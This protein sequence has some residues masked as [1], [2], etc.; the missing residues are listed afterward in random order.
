MEGIEDAGQVESTDVGQVESSR[1]VLP[2]AEGSSRVIGGFSRGRALGNVLNFPDAPDLLVDGPF[3]AQGI[4]RVYS[5]RSSM[6]SVHKPSMTMK[7]ETK[8]T[9]GPILQKLGRKYSPVRKCRIFAH[10]DGNWNVKGLFQDALEE[11]EEI[12]W[13]ADNGQLCLS[14]CAE[15][16]DASAVPTASQSSHAPG[17]GARVASDAPVSQVAVKS[18]D[19]SSSELIALLN[20]PEHLAQSIKNA[21]LR[22]NYAKYKAC[23]QAQET[24]SQKIK[25]GTWP[26]G[27]KK[28]TATNIIE[29]FV[30]RT[31]WHHYVKPA[32]HDISHFEPLKQWL[33]ST[34][35]GPADAAVWGSEQ[36]S[37]S[38]ADLQ[39]EKD[40]RQ[41]LKT[42]KKKEGD[43]KGQTGKGKKNQV[44]KE[45]EEKKKGKKVLFRLFMAW[46]W[47]MVLT[48]LPLVAAASRE[49][50]PFPDVPFAVFSKFVEDHFISTVSLSTVLMVLFSVTENTDLLSLH[51]RQRCSERST[52]ATGWIRCFGSAVQKR[53]EE[54]NESLLKESDV[55]AEGSVQ[56]TNIAI[57]LKL[58]ALARVGYIQLT[59]QAN[60]RSCNKKALFQ[61][62]RARDVPLVRLIKDFKV[63]EQ[64][65]VYSGHCKGCKTLY[66][67]DHERAPYAS[68]VGQHERVYLNSA[69]Y[70]KIGQSLWVDRAF[71]AAVLSGMYTFH[72][73][74]AAYTEFWNSAFD[75]DGRGMSRRQVWQ[76]FVQESIRL[77][78]S[79]SNNH[80]A[81]QDGLP[82]D[83]VTKEAFT[84]LGENGI[85]RSADQHECSECTHKYKR[86]SDVIPDANGN[87]SDMVGMEERIIDVEGQAE[88][89]QDVDEEDEAAQVKMVVVDGIVMGYTHC[90][91]E[92]CT[93][94]LGNARGGVYCPF[95]ELAHGGKCHAAN[96]A[97]P[98]VEGTLAC[99]GHQAKWRRHQANHRNNVLGGY[100]RALRRPDETLPW[101]PAAP[102]PRQVQQ[103]DEEQVEQQDHRTKDHFTPGCIVLRQ[104]VLLVVLLLDGPNLQS[105]SPLPISLTSWT[106]MVLKTVVNNPD[107]GEWLDTSRFIVDAYHYIN[108]RAS[109]DLCRTWCNPAPLNG[110]APNLVIAE[111]NAQGQLYYKRAFN[112][113]A[114]EQLN[115]WL[116][117]FESILKRMTPGNFDWFL[118]TMLF[119]HTM[120]VIKKQDKKRD[121]GES[122]DEGDENF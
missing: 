118:H 3:P 26:T 36:T 70:I 100:R 37:Y 106:C 112:T 115:A 63:H 85:L 66:Y 57:G 6:P 105:L 98:N 33:E 117:G 23:L 71:T 32:F 56:K 50:Q 73:S 28:P 22:I 91:F 17:I 113:Q 16:R 109:D 111:R 43:N 64:V 122:E 103:H 46:I 18:G 9:L 38:F 68:I 93:S 13:T 52:S 5:E 39:K 69:K 82:I 53:L 114:C 72:A 119:Y 65:Q 25:Q 55:D 99:E 120:Q 19:L 121:G 107:W 67:A 116:G 87:V 8:P 27:I 34:E 83:E 108:H 2:P 96:C 97:Y 41:Q 15:G 102:Q 58:D 42:G 51:Y 35:G 31:Y 30:S 59:N 95:H 90:A 14:L 86:A 92:G 81:I 89:E 75:T 61:W 11:D 110:S 48:N 101:M 79:S 45:G 12:T 10:E 88:A 104:F 77:V 4:V 76:A 40:R 24:L 80:F 78:A 1:D 21:G 44:N 94:D 47:I 7:A 20:V 84:M 29:L 49:Q 74:A 62:T 60:S 54:E